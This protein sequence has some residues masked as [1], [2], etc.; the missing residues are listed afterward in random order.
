MKIPIKPARRKCPQC[1][2]DLVRVEV[3]PGTFGLVCYNCREIFEMD[4]ELSLEETKMLFG[5]IVDEAGPK[6][7]TP[8]EMFKRW[9]S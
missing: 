1:Y 8:Q 7:E 4:R 9:T 5:E 2:I 6:T 3:D